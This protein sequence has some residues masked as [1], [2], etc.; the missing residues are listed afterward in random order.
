M[1]P[2]SI[3]AVLFS[4]LAS[5]TVLR[6]WLVARS[7]SAIRTPNGGTTT[8]RGHCGSSAPYILARQLR[9]GRRQ[10][11]GRAPSPRSYSPPPRR[12]R[13]IQPPVARA[14]AYRGDSRRQSSRSA[15]RYYTIATAARLEVEPPR[16]SGTVEFSLFTG[17]IAAASQADPPH[18]ITHSRPPLAWK[19]SRRA[20]SV[21]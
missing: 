15:A 16:S 20:P 10:I 5:N 21:L 18:A 13:W 17:E 8:Q 9:S 1:F 3:L 14:A 19:L 11:R 7:V 6:S 12:R 2:H 4:S